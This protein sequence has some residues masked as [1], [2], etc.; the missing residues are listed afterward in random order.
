MQTIKKLINEGF[1]KIF[2]ASTIN[3]IINFA[4]SYVLIR[5]VSKGEYGIYSYAA[6]IYGFL[7]IFNVI[8]MDSAALQLYVENEGNKNRQESI[9]SYCSRIALTVN[10]IICVCIILFSQ[11]AQ[12]SIDG[13]NEIL[14][15][16]FLQPIITAMKVMQQTYLRANVRNDNYAALNIVDSICVASFSIIGSITLGIKG[17]IIS[18]YVA[19]IIVI[20]IGRYRYKCYIFDHKICKD[21]LDKSSIYKIAIIMALNNSLATILS[22]LGTTI[23]GMIIS[24]SE[25]IASYK[26]ASTLPSAFLFIP[27]AVMIFALPYFIRK[28]DNYKWVKKKSLMLLGGLVIFNGAISFVLIVA[29][30][31]AIKILFGNQY[32]DCVPVFRILMLSYFFQA[33]F[34]IPTSNILFSQRKL[35]SNTIASI[36]GIVLMV[37]LN[38]SLVPYFGGVGTALSYFITYL[39]IVLILVIH[40]FIVINSLRSHEID[41]SKSI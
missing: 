17:L 3:K 6:T 20:F 41:E 12:L 27:Q 28:K 8:G 5:V 33:A 15:L 32:L 18:Q 31:L 36:V 13:S 23:L 40:L 4:Y 19:G 22:L 9:F 29:A 7:M 26:V 1:L 34:R 30:P 37:T 11:F 24:K 16:M 10:L 38:Y 25:V 2:S 35:K 21:E 14:G 39:V